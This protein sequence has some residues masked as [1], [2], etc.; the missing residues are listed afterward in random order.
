LV[1]A[2]NEHKFQ[3]R[4]IYLFALQ[5]I[6]IGFLFTVFPF[7]FRQPEFQCRALDQ[8]EF[9]SCEPTPDNCQLEIQPLSTFSHTLVA[10]FGLYCDREI[11]A[12]MAKTYFTIAG[13][14]GTLFITPLADL[15]GRRPGLILSYAVGTAS[16]FILPFTWNWKLFCILLTISG[17]CFSPFTTSSMLLV[18]EVSGNTNGGFP[19]Q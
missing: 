5:R 6:S 18:N 15:V 7:L 9:F 8:E 12:T 4:L 11:D 19:S 2:G 16:L 1:E 10:Q 13:T 17:L 14:I 3:K